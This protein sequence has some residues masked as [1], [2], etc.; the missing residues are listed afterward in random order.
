MQ[1]LGLHQANIMVWDMA[2]A[3]CHNL[4]DLQVLVKHLPAQNIEVL[5]IIILVLTL[6][7]HHRHITHDTSS[8]QSSLPIRAQQHSSYYPYR[9]DFFTYHSD[10]YNDDFVSRHNSMWK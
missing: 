6:H 1:E 3:K 10:D 2:M 8:T 7:N 9:S 5:G 4:S